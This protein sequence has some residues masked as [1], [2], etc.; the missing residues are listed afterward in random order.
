ME[1][2]Q[3]D[4]LIGRR[5]PVRNFRGTILAY[6]IPLDIGDGR[7][8][9]C[10]IRSAIQRCHE[11]D[12]LW[13]MALNMIGYSPI[14]SPEGFEASMAHT[15]RAKSKLIARV[16]RLKGQIEAVER[17]LEDEVGCAEI[18][19]L[20]ASIRGAMNGLTAELFEEHIRKHVVDP[21]HEK[22]P[23]KAQGAKELIDVLRTYMK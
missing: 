1:I 13:R 5:Q 15:I 4:A 17:S 23:R 7:A 2:S 3:R 19:Q 18:L 14:L 8:F 11:I 21:L 22:D 6:T 20:V 10:R 16:R 12:E 9:Q